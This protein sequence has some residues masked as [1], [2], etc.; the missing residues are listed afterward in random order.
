[1][2][3]ATAALEG[4][5]DLLGKDL[6]GMSEEEIVAEIACLEG[7]AAGRTGASAGKPHVASASHEVGVEAAPTVA[8]APD[9]GG[10]APAVAAAPAPTT[11]AALSVA[12]LAAKLEKLQMENDRLAH[13]LATGQGLTQLNSRTRGIA[14]LSSYDTASALQASAARRKSLAAGAAGSATLERQIREAKERLAITQ[15]GVDVCIVMDCTGSMSNCIGAVKSKALDIMSLA[16]MVHPD[17]AT[18]LAFVGYRDFGGEAGDAHFVVHDF[19]DKSSFSSLQMTV[20]PVRACGGGNCEDV[21]GAL[22]KVTELSWR[23]STRLLI[24]FGDAP[25]HGS[26]YHDG[27]HINGSRDSYPAGNPD[28]LIPEELLKQLATCRIDY[29]FARINCN[30]DIM[31]SI[32]KQVYDE[33]P[34][35]AIFEMHNY[36][37]NS[38][39]FMPVVL[40]SITSSMRRSYCASSSRSS[41]ASSGSSGAAPKVVLPDVYDRLI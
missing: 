17:A 27:V 40:K 14:S 34:G 26:R 23:S 5:W 10:S 24:H 31:T 36:S 32:F 15:R 37:D 29:H 13:V 2:S 19:V 12:E 18:R 8:T 22:K 25:C 28:G 30:T 11:P 41:A 35:A 38:Q 6:E 21:T 39:S 33:S 7:Q 20:Q 3:S 4:D 9:T 1:M 16:P